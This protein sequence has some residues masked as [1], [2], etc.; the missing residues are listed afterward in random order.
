MVHRKCTGFKL[1]VL[2]SLQ[3]G[4]ILNWECS[5]CY[6]NK[7]PLNGIAN[8]E[9]KGDT[10]NS[11]MN[12]PCSVGTISQETNLNFIFNNNKIN[13]NKSHGPDPYNNIEAVYNINVSCDYYSLHEF[14]KLSNKIKKS[15]QLPISILHTNI[16]SLMHNFEALEK[17]CTDLDYSFDAIALSETW[18]P[19]SKLN[20]FLPQELHGYHPLVALPGVSLKSGTGIYIRIS[21]SFKE[22]KKL[23]IS[24]S[25]TVS[26]FQ[27]KFIEIVR[28]KQKNIVIIIVYRHPKTDCG[29]FQLALQ[30][31]ATMLTKELKSIILVGDFNLNAL[32]Y[33]NDLSTKKFVDT[34]KCFLE[35]EETNIIILNDYC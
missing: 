17:L 3:P 26:E 28:E 21:L 12:C 8:L 11:N 9:L 22:R 10:F 6:A 32:N 30:E 24:H 1:S 5:K 35:Y 15:K 13:D 19:K 14:H 34:E 7:F 4:D 31:R 27:M 29:S 23:D 33:E 16:C 18:N 20:K 2:N 25:D